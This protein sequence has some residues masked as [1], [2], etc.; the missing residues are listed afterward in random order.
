MAL[1]IPE[2]FKSSHTAYTRKKRCLHPQKKS[3]IKDYPLFSL[4]YLHRRPQT[5][6]TTAKAASD[7]R[8]FLA[9]TTM[10]TKTNRQDPKLRNQD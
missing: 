8:S 1:N 2:Q 3:K 10:P 9:K 6:C 4:S 7:T 5:A